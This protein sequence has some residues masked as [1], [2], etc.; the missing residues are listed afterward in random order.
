MGFSG[1][2]DPTLGNT[3]G[4]IECDFEAVDSEN[5]VL[6]TSQPSSMEM[7]AGKNSLITL[8]RYSTG[9]RY[10]IR[11]IGKDDW[12]RATT[13]QYIASS[14]LVYNDAS[15]EHGGCFVS[16]ANYTL[17]NKN[18]ICPPAIRD[19]SSHRDGTSID[20][21]YPTST[22]SNP[23]IALESKLELASNNPAIS[24]EVKDWVIEAREGIDN[25]TSSSSV[26]LVYIA[27]QKWLKNLLETGKD[28][29]G[30]LVDGLT[31]WDTMSAKVTS[32]KGHSDHMHIEF[33]P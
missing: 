3:H 22:M 16:D 29:S 12:M 4:K 26:K 11:D 20:I 5:N 10:G 31:S 25:I 17:Y 1:I 21:H 23:T 28:K 9:P 7:A 32:H 19:H 13:R 14:N 24:K 30:N 2:T 27:K 33:Y 15:R 18:T 6:S 8:T